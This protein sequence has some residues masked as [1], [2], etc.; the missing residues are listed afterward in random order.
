[1]RFKN[2]QRWVANESTS[3]SA[4][5]VCDY[6]VELTP[7]D[8]D[9]PDYFIDQVKKSGKRFHLETVNIEELL[10]KDKSLAEYVKSGEIRYGEDGES[11]LEPYDD[12][13]D[14]PIVIFKGEVIDGY[15]RTSTLYNR[16]VKTIKAYISE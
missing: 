1:M 10:K 12:E 11:D 13:L 8:S 3:M 16:G 6:I 5:E 9:V 2:F 15:S 4:K 7:S 14:Y